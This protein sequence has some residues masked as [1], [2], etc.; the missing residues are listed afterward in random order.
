MAGGIEVLSFAA[1]LRAF[2][3]AGGGANSSTMP[4][5][6]NSDSEVVDVIHYSVFPN[7]MLFGGFA[8]PLVYRVRPVQGDP[9]RC[10]FEVYLLLPRTGDQAPA[11]APIFPS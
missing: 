7:L 5:L 10:L 2:F 1:F 4:S 6:I 3:C 9:Q 8:V 11:P